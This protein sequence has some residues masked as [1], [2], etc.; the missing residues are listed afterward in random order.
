WQLWGV[1]SFVTSWWFMAVGARLTWV[2]WGAAT[3]GMVA[4][5]SPASGRAV[6]GFFAALVWS[7]LSV[8]ALRGLSLRPHS[9]T[10]V[11]NEVPDTADDG[12]TRVSAPAVRERDYTQSDD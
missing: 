9:C 4:A 11:H 1:S 5:A 10:H 6:A 7:A 2:V 12:R 8:F 3:V